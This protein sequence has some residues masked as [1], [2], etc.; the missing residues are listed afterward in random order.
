M[1]GRQI[2]SRGSVALALA[3]G[4]TWAWANEHIVDVVWSNAGGFEYSGQLGPGKFIEVCDKLRVGQ[5]IKWQFDSAGPADFNIHFHKG[6]ETV[7]PAKLSQ[8][9]QAGDVLQVDT[10]ETYC[11]MWRNKSDNAVALNV[12]LQR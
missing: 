3:L 12:R 8:V 2:W 6:K 10:D 1:K 9:R 5:S 11:W 4:G 7:F